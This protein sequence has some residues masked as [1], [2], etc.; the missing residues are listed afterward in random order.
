[1]LV[2]EPEVKAWGAGL[3]LLHVPSGLFAQGHYMAAEFSCN[4]TGAAA[5]SG[6]WGQAVDCKKDANQWLVQAGITKNWF[7]PGN[8]ALFG[9]YSKSTDWGAV[10]GAGRGFAGQAG[11]VDVLGV[12]DTELTVWGIGITQ[13]IDAAATEL[14]LNYRHFSAD[15]KNNGG[16]TTLPTEDF[17]AVIG[18]A[19]VKF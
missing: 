11:S 6:Y 15:I 18:G 17:D 19:R 9:E 16:Q 12:T 14:Y 13:N 2:P 3:S 10:K 4:G 7:G 8:T 1:L 5:Q